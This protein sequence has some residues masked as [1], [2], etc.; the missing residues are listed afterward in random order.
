MDAETLQLL[1]ERG[2]VPVLPPLGFDGDGHTYRVN[3]DAIAVETAIALKAAKVI[4]L[5][6]SGSLEMD[7]RLVRQLSVQEA[8][9]AAKKEGATPG[10]NLAL[11]LGWAARAGRG[12]VPRAH[13]LNG[14]QD[15]ALL[16]EIFSREGIGTMVYANDY[17]QIRRA[18]KRDVK[19]ILDLIRQSVR[20]EALAPRTRADILAQLDDYWVLEVDRNIVGCVALHPYPAEGMAE[21]ACLHVSRTSENA[22]HGRKLVTW[23]DQLAR[24][25]GIGRL[26]AL[27]TQAFVYLQQKGGFTEAAP[28]ILPASRREKYE[29]SGRKSKVLVKNV[30]PGAL[31]ATAG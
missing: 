28:E 20:D 2:M 8:E 7:G 24:E 29:A 22:G 3:S 15:E 23:V 12:G 13:L 19:R 30:A 1:L 11:K 26:F 21:L 31:T 6:E 17:E 18:Q 14:H 25:H 10:R 5:C 16:T 9:A 27:S 4:F